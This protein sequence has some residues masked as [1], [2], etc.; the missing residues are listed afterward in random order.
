MRNLPQHGK[1]MFVNYNNHSHVARVYISFTKITT[2]CTHNNTLQNPS[3]DFDRL[4]FF[5]TLALLRQNCA[6][7]LPC[8]TLWLTCLQRIR[9]GDLEHWG[10]TRTPHYTVLYFF[11]IEEV[12][13][14]TLINFRRLQGVGLLLPTGSW[15]RLWRMDIYQE[16]VSEQHGAGGKINKRP[17]LGLAWILH[18][19]L[20]R[21]KK[22]K[23][24][25]PVFPVSAGRDYR[26]RL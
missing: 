17:W 3:A 16:L 19:A 6:D 22:R 26:V 20:R 23:K 18:V 9:T 25:H 14:S 13:S 15:G 5:F 10:S 21:N 1:T 4:Q 2:H 12:G 7:R 11:V 8:G 24:G